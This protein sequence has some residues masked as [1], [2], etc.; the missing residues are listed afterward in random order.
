MKMSI[1]PFLT[2]KSQLLILI[3]FISVF[4]V[5]AQGSFVRGVE[6]TEFS[7][8]GTAA[9]FYVSLLG[10]DNWSGK[11]AEP[12]FNKTDGPFATIERAKNAVGK[13]KQEVY[14]L[15]KKAV[16]KRFIGTPHQYGAGHDIVVLI[17]QGVYSLE[18]TLNFSSV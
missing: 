10:N 12:N 7:L 5:C 3:F 14:K 4:Q 1:N 6:K 15:K 18:N 13:L 8:T 17:R 16:D 11:L 9:D 2:L